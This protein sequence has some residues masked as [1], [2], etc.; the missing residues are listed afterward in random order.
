MDYNE[1]SESQK[2]HVDEL[3]RV[4]SYAP[5][6]HPYQQLA[7]RAHPGVVSS[8]ISVPQRKTWWTALEDD[9]MECDGSEIVTEFSSFS[10]VEPDTEDGLSSAPGG[11]NMQILVRQEYNIAFEEMTRDYHRRR[12]DSRFVDHD[13]NCGGLLIRGWKGTGKS[14]FLRYAMVRLVSEGQPVLFYDGK[15]LHVFRDRTY[16]SS[17]PAEYSQLASQDLRLARCIMLCDLAYGESVPVEFRLGYNFIVATLKFG[18]DMAYF[19]QRRGAQT[20]YLQPWTWPEY[21][22]VALDTPRRLGCLHDI[23]PD[24]QLQCGADSAVRRYRIQG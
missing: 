24:V 14:T 4:A 16:T 13:A 21:Y 1:A 2:G 17:T 8:C 3:L 7:E 9:L 6:T 10:F 22:A 19:K 23:W 12:E 11:I 15:A 20:F 18:D 5:V